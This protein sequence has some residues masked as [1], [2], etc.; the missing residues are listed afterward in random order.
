M[1]GAL[2]PLSALQPAL[3]PALRRPTSQSKQSAPQPKLDWL[4]LLPHCGK[5]CGQP[6]SGSALHW[7]ASANPHKK[8]VAKMKRP[9]PRDGQRAPRHT[10]SGLRAWEGLNTFFWRAVRLALAG[11]LCD[12]SLPSRHGEERSDAAI[13]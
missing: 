4:C 3:R 10:K 2:Y 12:H 1:G 6:T 13:H 8:S 5:R 11:Q 9:L 7:P